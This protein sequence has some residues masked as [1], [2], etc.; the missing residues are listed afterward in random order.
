LETFRDKMVS[1]VTQD[2]RVIMVRSA[3]MFCNFVFDLVSIGTV[4]VVCY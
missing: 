3:L 4:A 1:V 2:G